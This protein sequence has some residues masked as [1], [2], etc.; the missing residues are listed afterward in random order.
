MPASI[1]KKKHH[2]NT[3]PQL[4]VVLQAS[5]HSPNHSTSTAFRPPRPTRAEELQSRLTWKVE[6]VT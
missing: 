5:G 6:K 1:W 4:Y 3:S 2:K